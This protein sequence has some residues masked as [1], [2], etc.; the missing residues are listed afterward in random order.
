MERVLTDSHFRDC[1]IISKFGIVFCQSKT[2][3]FR[4]IP[5]MFRIITHVVGIV[6]YL[7]PMWNYF[8][9]IS[10][11]YYLKSFYNQLIIATI[12]FNDLHNLKSII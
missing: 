12:I 9:N 2:T 10:T 7:V 4:V 6:E 8:P 11:I 3:T 5:N 1:F